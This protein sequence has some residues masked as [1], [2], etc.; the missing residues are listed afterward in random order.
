MSRKIRILYI[1]DQIEHLRAGTENQLS[2]L[3]RGLDRNIFEIHLYCLMP[4]EWVNSN[5]SR[6]LNCPIAV[7]ECCKFLNP[8]TYLNMVELVSSIRRLEP[9][10]VHT[11]FP[12]ANTIGVL[13]AYLAGVRYIISSR[14]DHGQWMNPVSLF[15][16]KIA[17]RFA[18]AIHTNSY[19][20]KELTENIEGVSN[21]RIHVIYNGIDPYEFARTINPDT[22]N[23]KSR[24]GIP[25]MHRVVGVV[26]NLRPMKHLHTFVKA[27]A[28]VREERKDISFVM[29]GDGPSR[30]ALQTL[31]LN[32]KLEESV[33]FAG[34]QEDVN[35]YLRVFDIAV[36]CSAQ[37]GLS[38]A[39]IEYMMAGV[40]CIVAESGG[41]TELIEND[42]N[43]YT[44]PLDD[45]QTLA[46]LILKL[47]MDKGKRQLFAERSRAKA[48][49]MF[50][51][52]KM[53]RDFEHYYTNLLKT[54]G[55]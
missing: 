44:F 40:P 8:L 24:L 34:S 20:V 54:P 47:I 29:V 41:N 23:V 36:N 7:K 25:S 19:T 12:N 30:G 1:I 35:A 16:T 52:E 15:F 55:N 50:P 13:A 27:A 43:G 18:F 11:F 37:E 45:H 32:L 26:A 3:I 33:F 9:D 28:K 2:K 14:R 17:N 5:G 6:A 4:S 22:T 53:I 21:D 31:V 51:K 10:I 39:I 38:N 48:K 46:E 42:W 49:E